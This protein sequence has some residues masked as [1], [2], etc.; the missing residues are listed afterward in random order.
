MELGTGVFLS[1]VFVGGLVLY[2]TTK[3]RWNWKKIL[4]W[5]L[6]VVVGL[7]VIGGTGTYLYEQYKKQPQKMTVLWG[8][9]L[10]SSASDVRFARGV[11]SF[12]FG[13]KSNETWIYPAGSDDRHYFIDFKDGKVRSVMYFGPIYDAP[14]IRGVGQN[15]SPEEIEKTLGAPSYVSRSRDDLRRW[16]SFD[17]FNIGVQFEKNRIAGLGIY[18]PISGPLVFNVPVISADAWVVQLGSYSDAGNVGVLVDKLTQLG[19]AA[20]TEKYDSPQG[21]RTRVRAGPFSSQDAAEKARSTIRIIGIDGQ[22]AP[23]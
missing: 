7:S 21:P 1:A 18:D 23:K 11:P 9:A 22:V 13:E 16:Y 8:I 14:T 20:F 3:D 19:I 10:G 2:I 6:G 12:D 15:D 4:L 17:E 5:P